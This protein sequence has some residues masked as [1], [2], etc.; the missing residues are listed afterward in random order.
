LTPHNDPTPLN[1]L[2]R[3]CAGL[4]SAELW[5]VG[6]VVIGSILYPAILPA[7]VIIV[8]VFW[9]L[10]KLARGHWSVRTP[11]DY[12]I[13]LLLLMTAISSSITPLPAISYPQIYRLLSGIGLFY[14]IVNSCQASQKIRLLPQVFSLGGLV[15][16]LLAPLSVVW[17]LGKLPLMPASIYQRFSVLV[18]DSVHPNVIAGTL[19]L[20][21]PV[22]LAGLLFGWRELKVFERALGLL[23]AAGMCGVL[24]LSFSRGAW[25]ASGLAVLALVILR[26]RRGWVA[27]VPAL[28]VLAAGF[29]RSGAGRA[30]DIL[31]ASRTVGSY[32]GRLEVWSRALDMIQDFPFTGIGIGL[33][34]PLAD[35]LYPFLQFEPGKVVHAHNLFLQ[36][37]V[38]LGLPGLIAWLWI[39]VVALIHAG[40]AY[41]NGQLHKMSWMTALGAGLLGSQIALVVHGLTD[42][43]TWGMVRPAPL[44]WALWG[45]VIAA[46]L[47]LARTQ[48][49]AAPG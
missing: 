48:S 20:L 22:T 44:V 49:T 21:L 4:V 2:R 23:S 33:F 14:A 15:L 35:R 1:P 8:A 31:V 28:L 6:G 36:I 43:V 45:T 24:I 12:P 34:Q 10:H 11:C 42:A 3:A 16:A 18:A 27:A 37:A 47:W 41:R 25:L 32:N 38:D 13:L 26:W 17:P 29:Y 7:A 9:P 39:L 19:A 5:V 30:L 40:R 46:A